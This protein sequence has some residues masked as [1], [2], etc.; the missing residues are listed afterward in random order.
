MSKDTERLI[1]KKRKRYRGLPS[2]REIP[3]AGITGD[4]RP[5]LFLPE[6][7]KETLR[8][9]VRRVIPTMRHGSRADGIAVVASRPADLIGREGEEEMDLLMIPEAQP[10]EGGRGFK[11]WANSVLSRIVFHGLD[12]EKAE[13]ETEGWRQAHAAARAKGCQDDSPP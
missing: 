5:E 6:E 8:F 2:I 10:A 13:V 12:G 3:D 7:A 9:G 1:L 11:Q 4:N